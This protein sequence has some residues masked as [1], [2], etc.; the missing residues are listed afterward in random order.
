MNNY[1]FSR[2]LRNCRKGI[3]QVYRIT[4]RLSNRVR[5]ML[6]LGVFAFGSGNIYAQH[7]FSVDYNYLSQENKKQIKA[8]VSG[9]SGTSLTRSAK[10]E[11]AL[12]LSTVQNTKIIIL[13]EE[14]GANIVITPTK[15][16]PSQFLL[17]PFFIEELKRSALGD[18][19]R[20][21]II[22]AGVDFSV[23]NATS[24]SRMTEDVFIPTYFYGDKE[25]VKEAL[26]QNR[27]IIH[28]F[29]EKPRLIPAFPDDPENLRYVSQVEEEMSY[30]VY[31]YK[32]PDGSLYIFDEHFIDPSAENNGGGGTRAGPKLQFNL[33]G[34]LTTQ[35]RTATEYAYG[36]WSDQLA[37][38]VPI[39]INVSFVSMGA[40]ILGGS[41][42]QPHYW[43]SATSTWYCSS[44]GNQLAGYDFAP[45]QRDIR[46]EMNSGVSW[47]YSTT[48]S[49]SS[50]QYDCV[51]IMLHEILHGLGFSA[52]VGSD[53]QYR[54]TT[55][56]G[57]TGTVTSYPGIFDRQLYQGTSGSN[58]PDLNQTQRASLVV[59]SNLYAGRPSSYLLAANSNSRVKMYAPSTWAAGSSVSHW[60]NSVS[61]TTFMKFSAA[62]GFRCIVINAREIGI[63]RDIGWE[64]P[65]LPPVISGPSL[66][67][68][69]SPNQY[70]ANNW[71]SIN[72]YWACSSNLSLPSAA[73][74]PS[75]ASNTTTV[76]AASSSSSGSGWV[77]VMSGSTILAEYQVWV[78]APQVYI[79]GPQSVSPWSNADYTLHASTSLSWPLA[80]FDWSL[81]TYGGW[82]S[83]SW[84]QYQSYATVSVGSADNYYQVVGRIKN[85]CGWS[86]Y[87]Y[88]NI[89]V[90]NYSPS[91]PPPA[92]PNPVSDILNV[93]LDQVV[94]S[95]SGSSGQQPLAANA[96]F[97]IRLYD[98]QGNLL[99]N[100]AAKG[101]TIQFNVSN[102][103]DGNYFLHIYDGVNSAPEIQQ[104]VVQH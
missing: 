57:T 8:Q 80:Q 15:D 51:T 65:T 9:I 21:L 97:D 78:G 18:A 82:G 28:I 64:I 92:Y 73:Q 67:C 41:Y 69:G 38:T 11:Y 100:S 23:R 36:L 16:A 40:G 14:T 26:P 56:S 89:Y 58:L 96:A 27:Q 95:R 98:P 61:F 19:D 85:T 6:I 42:F 29:K 70:S 59:S 49:P 50:S 66:I 12:S 77:R 101:G 90:Y 46:I 2:S 13:N 24:V 74:S 33:S 52:L 72:Y 35:Q 63:M 5:F 91:P 32:M 39:D 60:D 76:S 3:D 4:S 55:S 94:A 103:P 44:L 68:Y 45:A 47:N 53:G 20:F 22:E 84:N 86:S 88:L 87:A 34:T 62:T 102:L 48:S 81:G 7:L 10:G 25:N 93:D 79:S 104:I 83:I 17:Q 30:Y 75:T 37:G 1:Q 31:M 54:Y 43:D 71:L 99:R